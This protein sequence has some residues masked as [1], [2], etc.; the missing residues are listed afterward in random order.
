MTSK[1]RWEKQR[2]EKSTFNK[3][4]KGSEKKDNKDERRWASILTWAHPSQKSEGTLK[5]EATP[6]RESLSTRVKQKH[7]RDQKE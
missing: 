2:K 6:E 7:E 5:E 4:G 1:T 3:R